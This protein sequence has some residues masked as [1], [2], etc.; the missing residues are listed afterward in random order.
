M[1]PV[2]STI[3]AQF[4]ETASGRAGFPSG[5]ARVG[6]VATGMRNSIFN[7]FFA[8]SNSRVECEIAAPAAASRDARLEKASKCPIFQAVK[9]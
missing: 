2:M 5:Q 6:A 3:A 9:L 1:E 7:V 4:V 8:S